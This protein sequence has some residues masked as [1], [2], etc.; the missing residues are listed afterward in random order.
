MC[1]TFIVLSAV[2]KLIYNCRENLFTY[3]TLD[4][5]FSTLSS[6]MLLQSNC[7]NGNRFEY[8]E[9]NQQSGW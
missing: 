1:L 8:Q 4:S 9:L 2:F 6:Q 3:R 5:G 7:L